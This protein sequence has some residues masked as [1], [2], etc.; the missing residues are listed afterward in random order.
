LK[1]MSQ[2]YLQPYNDENLV[3]LGR[4]LQT[5]REEENADV[6][7]ETTLDYLAREF[8]YRLIW[9]ALYD[10]LEHRLFGKGG[11]TPTGDTI[12][13]KQWFN[14]HPGDLL[15]QVVIE[16]RPIGVPDLQ[17]ESRAGE[18]R[19]AARE[20][21]IQGTLLFPLRCKDR[22]FGV[23]L[24]GSHLW[25]VSPRAAEK[26]Q[27]SLLLGGL[28]AALYQIEVEW[29]RSSVKHPDRPLFQMLDQL[30]QLPTLAQRLEAVVKMTQQFVTPTRTN[31]YWYSPERRFFWH[32]VGN[33]QPIPRL[34]SSRTSAPGLM[35]AEVN[36]F[37]QALAAGQLVAIGA[38]RSLLKSDSTERLLGRLRARS[39]LAA[40]IQ[41][42]GELLGFLAVEDNEPHIWEEAERNYVRASA[43]L[44]AL[45]AG[46]EELEARLEETQKNANFT[47]EI[48]Q[49]IA[50]SND[51][52]AALKACA[53]LLCTRLDADRFLVL[54]EEDNGQFT[55][56]FG[57]QPLN[58]RPLS[59]CLAPISPKE[60]Q[61]LFDIA[62]VVMIEDLDA[63]L[64]LLQWRESLQLVGVRSL[65]I[66]PTSKAGDWSQ[67]GLSKTSPLLVIAHST[68]R[69]WNRTQR[70]LVSIVAQQINLLLLL[71]S[72]TESAQLS[73]HAHQTLQTGLSALFQ[74]P[75][76]P[77]QLEQIWLN[78]LATLLECPFA[79]LLGWTPESESATVA[80]TVV[81]DPTLSLPPDLTIPVASDALIQEALATHHFL[82]RSV[83]DLA[84]STHNWL[85]APGIG[86]LLVIALHTGA[87]PTTGIIVLADHEERPWPQHLLS[88]LETLT[89]QFTWL[90]HYQYS[91]SKYTQEVEDLQTLNWYKH[92]CLEMLHQSVCKSVSALLE[93]EA[94]MASS[95][96]AQ[97]LNSSP[98]TDGGEI[99]ST[100]SP[101]YSQPLQQM[102][103]QQLLH[104][105]EQTLAV[106]TPILKEEQWQLTVKPCPLPLASLLKRSLR[107]VQSCYEQQQLV[108]KVHN[109]SNK[110]VYGDRIKLECVLFELLVTACFHA[111]PG[112]RI[113]L[114]CCPNELK[115]SKLTEGLN[116]GSLKV[117]SLEN[118]LQPSDFQHSTQTTPPLGFS[119]EVREQPSTPL[120]E[121]LIAES[122]LL[123]ECL[124][125]L[126]PSRAKAPPSLN[127]KICQQVL[128]SWGGD[129][130]FYQLD[131][132]S[133]AIPEKH[134]YV[135]RLLLP[136]AK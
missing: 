31:L 43:Q 93:L 110:S 133:A 27:L 35:V 1:I 64:R 66:C 33:R 88:T 45:V 57:T 65:L 48:A 3:A 34:G 16:Q 71:G 112:S 61:W 68:P 103:R 42:Q 116:V 14:L 130:Q 69:T 104:Q 113:N 119:S 87:T 78:Y 96:N 70:E 97:R 122:G 62:E 46:T 129:L 95:T 85:G 32:R 98:A 18:W 55:L 127:L 123:D 101:T 100:P 76:D 13:L 135:S 136:L 25:G 109:S 94:K 11:I 30:M 77:I 6:L 107:R 52:T 72:Y 117:E 74:A 10:R 2:Q 120:L 126:T 17:Q 5:L 24:L 51:V 54:Q 63:D 50:H 73:F 105:L 111:Q 15:E 23:A 84:A 38:G 82:C 19:K 79:V 106:L 9:I 67:S 26:A 40:P 44:V 115:V 58:R 83:A 90:R 92:R 59:N 134:R 20:F 75:S 102:H 91:L 99:D 7:I 81:T 132:V 39:L 108:L 114:W 49:A 80:A 89:Q 4:T 12:F 131:G 124:H 22:C 60:R 29:Q 53:R 37:Y 8:N 118:N 21:G 47:V 36:D 56:V 86:Q 121:L 28:A 41:V 128:Q 125:A